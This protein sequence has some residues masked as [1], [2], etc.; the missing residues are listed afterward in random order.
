MLLVNKHVFLY[1]HATHQ[2]SPNWLDITNPVL[3]WIVMDVM[4]ILDGKLTHM[5]TDEMMIE[6][7]MLLRIYWC[8]STGMSYI[9]IQEFWSRSRISYWILS[10]CTGLEFG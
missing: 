4:E 6:S 3:D 1:Q 10:N 9:K 7:T 8:P 5:M 2:N